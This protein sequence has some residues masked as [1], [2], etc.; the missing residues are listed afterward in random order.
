MAFEK[1][2]LQ[3]SDPYKKAYPNKQQAIRNIYWAE[4]ISI[5]DDTD[6]GRIR[7]RIPDLDKKIPN[8]KLPF[9]YPMEPKF[10]H[11]YPKVGEVVRVFIEDLEY[12]QRSRFWLGPIISQ[13]QKI[14]FDPIFTSLSTTNINFTSPEPAIS[15][16][17]DAKGVFPN[18]EDIAVLGRNN[19]DMILRERDVEIRAGQHENNDPLTL[20]KKNPSSIRGTYDITGETTISSTVLMGDKIA[21]ISHDG[22]PKFKAV[23]IDQNE[24]QRIFEQGHP[25][26][27]GDVIVQALELI[28]DVLINDHSH[29]YPN[30]PADKSGK[31]LE[32]EKIDFTQ[33]LQ[34]NI[35]I[36]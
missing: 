24:R 18:K 5:K 10:F 26:G 7:V 9:T 28:R 19:A 35:V 1:K 11:V 29:P 15:S 13:L 21:L 36:N 17:P 2:Y 14:N 32:L 12:P 8:S 31:V 23:E 6:G 34:K 22:I 33:I 30:L 27:R 3:E 20:N 4:V 16:Y 25:L